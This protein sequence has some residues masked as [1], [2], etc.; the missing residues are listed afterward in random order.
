MSVSHAGSG[1]SEGI[2]EGPPFRLLDL[3]RELRDR[4]YH[5]AYVPS[6]SDKIINQWNQKLGTQRKVLCEAK[7]SILLGPL[8]AA[9]HQIH[10]ELMEHLAS[11]P[12]E[13]VTLSFHLYEDFYMVGR[14][15]I[16]YA[17]CPK[18]TS[19][20][21]RAMGHNLESDWRDMFAYDAIVCC[22]LLALINLYRTNGEKIQTV[23]FDHSAEDLC[24]WTSRV[25]MR[26]HSVLEY[27]GDIRITVNV[28]TLEIIELSGSLARLVKMELI[29]AL[30]DFQELLLI[31]Q[32]R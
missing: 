3:P 13:T 22:E 28:R 30:E 9:S 26:N 24:E 4:V 27:R 14:V 6:S 31:D 18:V 16:Q 32:P 23:T 17:R 25:E 7:P 29:G 21:F 1:A 15:A 12:N 11:L 10:D 2:E 8:H 19:V 20:V 5:Y